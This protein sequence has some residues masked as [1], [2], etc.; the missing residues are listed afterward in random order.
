MRIGTPLSSSATRVMLLG[1]AA[2][3]DLV[4][5]EL[6]DPVRTIYREY[7]R[8]QHAF[9]LDGIAGSKVERDAYRQQIDTVRALWSH[10]FDVT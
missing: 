10:V 1:I 8:T 9:R 5:R 3:L 4:P 2:D 6:A 7:R